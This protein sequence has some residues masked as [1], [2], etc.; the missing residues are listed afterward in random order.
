MLDAQRARAAF[1]PLGQHFDTDDLT[2]L[3]DSA[4]AIAIA[5]M[6]GAVREVSVHR[7]FD[8][9]AFSLIAFGGA[10]PMHGLF[11]AEELGMEHALI[12]RFPGHLSA[13]GQMLADVRRD[14][15]VAWGGRL[16]DLKIEQVLERVDAM[17]AQGAELLKL[18]SIPA[19]NHRFELSAD[20][21]YVGQSFTLAVVFDPY[22]ESLDTARSRFD[23][24]HAETFGHAAPENDVEIVN[25]RLVST[26]LVE[27]PKLEFQS[28]DSAPESPLRRQVWFGAWHD[29]PVY[30]RESLPVGFSFRGPAIIEEA[31]GTTIVPKEW[32]VDVL[33]SG[34][35][36][37]RR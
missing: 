9:R 6:A 24:R 14:M 26:G 2:A 4:L 17:R 30:Y 37:C 25:L 28:T 35:L 3:A 16:S 10:G 15:V 11:V 29:T 22:N 7:G 34:A 33:S 21:R 27:K 32:D 13:L 12:P 19:T 1:R 23:S 36:R 5:K 8:P 18:E 31:G 20:M